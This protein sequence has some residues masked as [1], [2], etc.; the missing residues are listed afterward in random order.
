MTSRK[1][2]L[3]RPGPRGGARD[4]NRRERSK[5][6]TAA[7]LH[8]FLERG[9]DGVTIDD[10]TQATGV[11]KG[12]FYRYFADKSALVNALIAP[13]RGE[14]LSGLASCSRA[15]RRARS[16]GAMFEAYRAVGKLLAG[17]MLTQPG[18][19]RLYLQESRGPASG[20]RLKIVE[21]AVQ[22]SRLAVQI[23][24]KAHTHGLLRPIQPAVSALAVVGAVERLLL[25]VLREEDVGN[26]LEIPDALTTLVLDG[27]RWPG[28]VRPEP[29]TRGP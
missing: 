24:E 8:L 11:A 17:V 22:I 28:G 4:T 20:A 15:L 5:A 14:I 1:A 25:A 10:I 18:V 2:Q 6:L 12:T 9:I 7:A 23:T 27:L 26:P 21:L 16:V 3:R 19:V 29:K 13:V